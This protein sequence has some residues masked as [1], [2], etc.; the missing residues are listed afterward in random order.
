VALPSPDSSVADADVIYIAPQTE[1]E[2]AIAAIWQTVLQL[3]KV[4]LDDNFFDRGGTSIHMVQVHTR[5]H[6]L[7]QRDIPIVEMFNNPT[8]RSLATY[9]GQQQ[10]EQSSFDDIRD[11]SR[12]QRIARERRERNRSRS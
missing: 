1:M 12:Q 10:P 2:H 7:L 9:L 5:L 11:R 4:G 3:E 6:D 8:V